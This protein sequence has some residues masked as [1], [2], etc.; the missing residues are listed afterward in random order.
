MD[1]KKAGVNIDAAERWVDLIREGEENDQQLISQMREYAAVYKVSED[2]LLATGCD[3]IGTKLLWSL[4]GYGTPEGAAQ[5]LL[6]MNV[7]DLLCVGATPRLFLDY[8]AFSSDELLGKDAFLG[9]FI[10]GLQ[11]LCLKNGMI[12]AGGETAQMKDLYEDNEFDVAGFAIGF[13]SPEEYLHPKNIQIGSEVWA[14]P[15]SGP[16]S[17]GYTLL[18]KL[19]SDKALIEEHFIAPTRLYVQDFL[20]LKSYLKNTSSLSALEAAYHITGGG[21]TNLLRAHATDRNIAFD[22]CY[23]PENEAKWVQI[24]REKSGVSDYNLYKTFNMGFGMAFVVHVKDEEMSKG[25]K[26]LGLVKLGKVV[27]DDKW[28]KINNVLLRES[29]EDES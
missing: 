12:L 14:F 27:E 9:K 10:K 15:S 26:E 5:D 29:G 17:N 25:L 3:G 28:V 1:Y 21:W 2:Q 4:R 22:L 13:M 20:K 19:F 7:N 18:R 6:G 23:W 11:S 16:H 8:I 24:L